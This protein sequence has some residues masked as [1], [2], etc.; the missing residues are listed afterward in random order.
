MKYNANQADKSKGWKVHWNL[1]LLTYSLSGYIPGKGWR[2]VLHTDRIALQAVRP[3][4]SETGRQRVIETRQKN[5][6]AWLWGL[7]YFV[8]ADFWEI[9]GML[10][11]D[12]DEN[13]LSY[14]PYRSDKF[15]YSLHGV[16]VPLHDASGVVMSVNRGKPVMNVLGPMSAE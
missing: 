9:V 3:I 6:H 2:V 8:G 7:Q 14:N 12:I 16:W 13:N 11:V 5:V 10:K 1:H 15:F 4:V